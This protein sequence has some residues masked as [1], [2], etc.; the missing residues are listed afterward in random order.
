MKVRSKRISER[1]VHADDLYPP[2]SCSLR[3]STVQKIS[4]MLVT[5]YTYEM[6]DMG[7]QLDF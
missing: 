7:G 4:A 3:N 6:K 1:K 2:T 5:E